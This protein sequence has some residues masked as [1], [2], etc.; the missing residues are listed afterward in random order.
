M[1]TKPWIAID[2]EGIGRDPHRYIMLAASDIDGNSEVIEN[3]DG[4]TTKECLDFILDIPNTAR[5]CGYYLGY[6]W[7]KILGD[8]PDV[9]IY[10][11][12]R[13]ELRALP[14][15][16]GGGFSYIR[17]KGYRLHYLAGMFRVSNR[18]RKTTVWD[19]GKFFQAPFVDAIE[20][21]QVKAPLA[22]IKKMK[23]N[24]SS[25]SENDR[26]SIKAYCLS[27]CR[28]LADLATSLE[29]AH[30]DVGIKPKSW[31]GPG[32]TAGALMKELGIQ[33]KRGEC[34]QELDYIADC[35]FFGGRFEHS[36]IGL[37]R[38]VIGNDIISA[39]PYQ[40]FKLPC[41]QHGKWRRTKRAQDITKGV[42]ACVRYRIDDIG[43]KEVWGPLPCRL[44]DGTIVFPRGG[45]SGW[46]W[47][48]EFLVAQEHW[49][50]VHFGGEAWV[51][52]QECDC[53]PFAEL[54]NL[55]R[56]RVK[57]GKSGRGRITKLALNSVY[58]KLAQTVGNP[59]FASRIWS[60]MITSGTRAQL[61]RLMVVH[62]AR[63]SVLALA[64]DGLYSQEKVL[65]PEPPLTPDMLGAWE[66]DEPKDM[67]FVRP[68]IYWAEDSDTVRARG[69]GRKLLDPNSGDEK[70]RKRVLEQR[71][72]VID[73]IECDDKE[74][75]VGESEL[76][77]GARAC[78]YR[79][80]DGTYR[81]SKN[82]GNWHSIPAR[83]SL[84][85]RP[86]RTLTWGLH[87]LHGIESAPYSKT[88]ISDD[89]KAMK[90]LGDVFWGMRG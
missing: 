59:R 1:A 48:D 73:A 75:I 45:A 32:S 28:A 36:N 54:L 3:R 38:R 25:F 35:A 2:G 37:F 66:R 17:W 26:E 77:G 56:E 60:G 44:R 13:P 81:R 70:R 50:G 78:V 6:D 19:L 40:A 41:L 27:E 88:P 68:G 29:N 65:H 12:L 87:L 85:P 47:L 42:A 31:H 18:G 82:Y 74:V 67:V 63:E 49:N 69:L 52:Y 22:D 43:D 84:D 86:K 64:T 8:L 89:A 51:L 39:Y 7:T 4:L 83:V 79:L 14:Q 58:G 53:Q 20:A 76:F 80:R 10:R 15:D 33:D 61:L 21:W 46:V 72:K 16:E 55:F 11:L 57:L 62:T 23:D 90:V 5:V 30:I 71:A 9:S 34:P 24:R